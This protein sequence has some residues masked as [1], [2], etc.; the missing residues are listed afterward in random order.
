MNKVKHTLYWTLGIIISLFLLFWEL[1]R[2]NNYLNKAYPTQV[3]DFQNYISD[4][5]VLHAQGNWYTTDVEGGTYTRPSMAYISCNI[6]ENI[7]RESRTYEFLGTWI[8]EQFNYDIIFYAKN[9]LKALRETSSM[10]DE[11]TFNLITKEVISNQIPLKAKTGNQFEDIGNH[12]SISKLVDSQFIT[13]Q[14]LK[15][16]VTFWDTPI[17]KI[18]SIF[19]N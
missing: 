15:S 8:V 12:T 5:G 17:F 9:E 10:K 14:N 18:I 4:F 7:C 6:N 11:L 13:K 16:I 2:E 1:S 19:K 3:F